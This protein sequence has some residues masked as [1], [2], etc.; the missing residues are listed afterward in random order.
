[1]SVEF[2][3]KKEFK[4]KFKN[5]RFIVCGGSILTTKWVLTAAHCI[6]RN[7]LPYIEP[8]VNAGINDLEKTGQYVKVRKIVVHPNFEG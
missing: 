5:V 7:N 8:Y 2:V 6:T 4:E 1:M 3:T